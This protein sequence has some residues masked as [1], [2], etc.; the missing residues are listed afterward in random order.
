MFNHI[1]NTIQNRNLHNINKNHS[2]DYL[3]D[4]E[5]NLNSII[6]LLLVD[7][8]PVSYSDNFKEMK[9]EIKY[10]LN[11]LYTKHQ[12]MY[13]TYIDIRKNK[14]F[15]TGVLKFSII[16]TEQILHTIEIKNVFKI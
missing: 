2:S 11:L 5:E 9:E 3:S 7:N 13:N 8:E 12:P 10:Y 14:I 16:L 15:I 6:Y 1:I 4:L